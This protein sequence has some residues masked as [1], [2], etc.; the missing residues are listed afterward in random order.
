MDGALVFVIEQLTKLNN[1][2]IML[3]YVCF[4]SKTPPANSKKDLVL[5]IDVGLLTRTKHYKKFLRVHREF[6][7]Y[8][9]HG[10]GLK[11]KNGT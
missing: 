3:L 4:K 2:C 1:R 7:Q 9:V 5:K 8:R 11:P 6:K 10:V